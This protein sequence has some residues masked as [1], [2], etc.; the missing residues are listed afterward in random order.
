MLVVML[1]NRSYENS[2]K[3]QVSLA[4]ARGNPVE[5]ATVGTAIDG[6]P[7]DFARIAQG[8]GWYAE[9]PVENGDQVQAAIKRALQ[10]IR[11]E[12]R[13]ALI[14]TVTRHT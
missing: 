14:D 5:M 7:P 11:K 3:H 2:W 6:P 8:L 9:G 10:V 13:P 4:K 1:N 12:G